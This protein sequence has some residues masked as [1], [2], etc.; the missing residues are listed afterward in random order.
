MTDLPD[1]F[2]PDET[3]V[4]AD[5]PLCAGCGRD[6]GTPSIQEHTTVKYDG[7]KHCRPCAF[8]DSDAIVEADRELVCPSCYAHTA[9]RRAAAPTEDGLCDGCGAK[10]HV[11]RAKVVEK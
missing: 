11:A 6:L 8:E 1:E 2:I 3:A 10:F 5:T 9:Y 4:I 7:E